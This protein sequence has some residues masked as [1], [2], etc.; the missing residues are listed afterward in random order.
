MVFNNSISLGDD[1]DYNSQELYSYVLKN[2]PNIKNPVVKHQIEI[3]KML[4][5][6]KHERRQI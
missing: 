2:E 3:Y 4:R 5:L 1:Y 6:F